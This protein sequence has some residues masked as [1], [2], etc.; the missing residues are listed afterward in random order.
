MMSE[1]KTELVVPEGQVTPKG[2]ELVQQV[3]DPKIEAFDKFFYGKG[4]GH[5][6]KYEREILRSFAWFLLEEDRPCGA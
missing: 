5:L 1:M 2:M 4:G 3:I 6:S